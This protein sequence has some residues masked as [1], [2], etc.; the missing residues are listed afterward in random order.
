MPRD[1]SSHAEAIRRLITYCLQHFIYVIDDLAYQNMAPVN[2][3]PEIKTARQVALELVRLGVIGEEHADRVITVHSMSKTDCL[4]G[5]RL[6]VVEIRDRLIRQRFEQ[7][8]ATIRPNMVAIFIS[9]LFY[10]SPIQAVRTYW[11]LR[12]AIFSERVSVLLTAVENLPPDRNPFHLAI[13]PPTGSMYPRLAN[14]KITPRPVFGLAGLLAGTTRDW[15]AA[16]GD[17]CAHRKGI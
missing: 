6:A 3:L 17:I 8:N 1:R 15:L 4:A 12:N 9:Y 14:W 16:A 2:D 10:R 13:I 7:L 5:A 11:R